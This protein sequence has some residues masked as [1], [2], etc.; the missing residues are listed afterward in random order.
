MRKF[1]KLFIFILPLF[2]VSCGGGDSDSSSGGNAGGGGGGTISSTYDFQPLIIPT[3][4]G[5]EQLRM[6]GNHITLT[7]E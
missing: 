3:K 7:V 5:I 1:F 2:L 6:T 4:N